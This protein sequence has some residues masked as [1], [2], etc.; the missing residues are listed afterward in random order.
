MKVTLSWLKEYLPL[1][2]SPEK[3]AEVLTLAGIE[4][5]AIE[6]IGSDFSGVFSAKVVS[7]M[8]H[9]N[10]D[11]LCIA[12]VSDG[13]E[14]FQVVCGARNCRAGLITA[15]AKIGAKL[16]PDEQGKPFTIKKGKLRDVESFGML[17]GA[18]ELGL[19]KDGDGIME[20]PC[21]LPLGVNLSTLYAD[22]IFDVSLT[23]NLGHCL[24]IRG[25]AREL[26]ALL[27]IPLHHPEIGFEE[28]GADI[29]TLLKARV[30]DTARCH[31]YMAR[32]VQ[33]ITVGPSPDWL[34]KRLTSCGMRSINNVVDVSNYVMLAMGQPLHIFDYDTIQDKELIVKTSEEL[35][36]LKT[37][38]EIDRRIPENTLLIYDTK[39]PLAF[40]GII[41]GASSAVTSTTKH[42][43]IE[44]AVFSAPAIRKGCKD[45]GLKTDSSQR[46]ERGIDPCELPYALNL[47]AALLMQSAGGEIA[48]GCVDHNSHPHIPKKITCRIERVRRLLGLEISLR[49]VVSLLTRLEIRVVKEH[50]DSIEAIVP[51]YR[52]DL[53]EEIDLIEEIVRLYGYNNIPK[54]PPLHV[55]SLLTDAPM[56]LLEN[57]VRAQ[58]MGE[59]LQELITCDL[60]SPTLYGITQEPSHKH[61]LPLTV[62][63]SKSIDYSVLRSTLLSRL[64]E[65]IK[66]NIYQQNTDLAGFEIGRI[67]SKQEEAIQELSCAALILT[68]NATP[69]HHN[70]KA[71]ESDFYD[72]KGMVE[73]LCSFCKIQEISFEISHLHNFQPGR[74]ARIKQ[75]E[76]TL[77]VLGEIHPD[78]LAK[79]DIKQRVFYAELNLHELLHVQQRAVQ[80]APLPQFPGSERDWTLTVTKDTSL[81]HILQKIEEEKPFTL[82]Q[83]FMLDLFES[84]KL[85]PDRKNITLRFC[86][87]DKAKTLSYETIEEEH[88]KVTQKVAKK[89]E[90]CLL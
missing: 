13:T 78:T 35:A 76:K 89:L 8:A 85:G 75:G 10:A 62:L 1:S 81:A 82:T 6:T 47:A 83:V 86:Y 74:Q 45:L 64:L 70:P 71:R 39:K 17:C 24:S 59:G 20:L 80:V 18:D 37:L 38:D 16:P 27:M 49:E 65:C 63:H 72:L 60:I 69:H 90:D 19:A 51:S 57:Q 88:A 84:E 42:V 25:V 79:M 29:H 34:Q 12:M 11:K 26:S 53:Q 50:T 2:L 41:G 77:G 33:N 46:F 67:H 54:R 58:L 5:E 44:A 30:E 48:Q 87:R 36:L 3:I 14:E 56:F 31:R 9:P 28:K 4:V 73:N 22:V 61:I 66:H 52:N 15:L 43:V 40:A 55:S 23:P 7:T 21:D 32:M 68:G